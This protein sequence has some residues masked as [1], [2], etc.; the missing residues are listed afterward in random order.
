MILLGKGRS[1]RTG[2]SRNSSERHTVRLDDVVEVDG[3]FEG[4]FK[5]RRE[6]WRLRIGM[7]G[8]GGVGRSFDDRR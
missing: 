8:T 5:G 6:G 3:A 4:A 2:I 1:W 7:M